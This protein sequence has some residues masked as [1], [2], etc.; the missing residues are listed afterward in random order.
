MKRAVIIIFLIAC[1]AGLLCLWILRRKIRDGGA[2]HDSGSTWWIWGDT[3]ASDHHEIGGGSSHHGSS[4][5]G[6]GDGGW[7][8]GDSSGG[9]GGG[10]GGGGD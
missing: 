2:D 1:A 7:A 5:G 8:G 9:D 6:H 3:Q 4:D 10:S